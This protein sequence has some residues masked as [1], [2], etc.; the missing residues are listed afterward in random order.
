MLDSYQ[1]KQYN[2]RA[3]W[4]QKESP[5]ASKDGVWECCKYI[6]NNKSWKEDERSKKGVGAVVVTMEGYN[7]IN[8][9]MGKKISIDKMQGKVR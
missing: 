6:L 4:I 5:V 1:L 9:G 8:R 2:H 3:G 7:Y